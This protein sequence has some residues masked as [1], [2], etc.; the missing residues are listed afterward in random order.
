MTNTLIM[1][2]LLFL[3]LI[4]STVVSVSSCI[5]CDDKDRKSKDYYSVDFKDLEN[6]ILGIDVADIDVL[7]SSFYYEGK[8]LRYKLVA[9]EADNVLAYEEGQ[10]VVDSDLN[11]TFV[12]D[13][14]PT[15]VYHGY[16]EN[17]KKNYLVSLPE[18]ETRELKFV[19]K[20]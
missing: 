20:K 4:L 3:T 9:E 18:M 17:D 15:E 16:F 14:N 6:D 5:K 8:T 19:L 10:A 13:A 2:K 11:I 12:P 7:Y 1:K